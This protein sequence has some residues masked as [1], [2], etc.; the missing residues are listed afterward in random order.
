MMRAGT[1]A[2]GNCMR[3]SL[4]TMAASTAL[5]KM[6]ESCEPKVNSCKDSCK[7]D[8]YERVLEDCLANNGTS[9]NA[10]SDSSNTS[11]EAEVF[12]QRNEQIVAG[13]DRADRICNRE[14]SGLLSDANKLMNGLGNSMQASLQC[15][16]QTSSA[17]GAN[18]QAVPNINNCNTNPSLAGCEVYGALGA[19]VPGAVGYDAKSCN[20]LQ[21]PAAA[22]CNSAGSTTP[23]TLFGGNLRGSPAAG[24]SFAGGGAAAGGS[25]GRA[26]NLD[27]SSAPDAVQSSLS[28]DA[29]VAAA[30][31]GGAYGGS[32]GAGGSGNG[33][34]PEEAALPGAA[35]EGGLGGLFNQAKN[36]VMNALGKGGS[37]N[38]RAAGRNAAAE[39]NMKK[40]KPLRGLAN[41]EGMGTRNMD[42]WKMVNMCANGETCASNRNN[43]MMT[44]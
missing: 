42:I 1:G 26:G 3:A 24:G 31:P 41:S 28:G 13:F 4:I 40:F 10:L 30:K 9:S 20:C 22:G 19:C 14:L 18:C 33:N 5:E 32:V 44:P 21:N 12:R 35:P 29:T 16:C 34:A 25:G 2:Q 39:P 17:A 36:A 38:T 37:R 6:G 7:S 23:A 8:S 27:L 11:R 15:A 43:Y